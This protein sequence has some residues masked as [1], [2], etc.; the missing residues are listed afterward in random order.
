VVTAGTARREWL[1]GTVPAVLLGLLLAWVLAR[2]AGPETE[3]IAGAVALIAGMTVLGLSTLKVLG[4]DTLTPSVLRLVSALAAVWAVSLLISAWLGAAKRIGLSLQDVGINDFFRVSG[5]T[6]A[7]IAAVCALI[8]ALL[9]AV[10][11]RYPS[12]IAGE[13]VT[14]LAALGLVIGPVTGHLGQQ[15]GGAVLMAVHVLAASW[16]CGS[17]AALALTVR[18]RKGW[19][20]SLPTFS[21][22]AQWLV[23][24]LIISGV[25]AAIS[26][27]DSISDVWSTGYGRILI[28]KSAGMVLLLAVA[29]DQRRRWLPAAEGHRMAEEGSLRR[30]VIEV[31][32]MA[33]VIGLAAGL[34]TTAPS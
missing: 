23:L 17:L 15:T 24:V 31:V 5:T 13:A 1:L 9:C 4:G 22:Y 2:P 11:I 28:A 16:W 33:V 14:A 32:L 12:F 19:A 6:A 20:T 27:L 3:S 26:E 10:W 30:A 7:L 8:V 25:V 34:G 18:G 29:V 21:R